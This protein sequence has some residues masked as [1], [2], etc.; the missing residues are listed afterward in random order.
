MYHTLYA[1][2]MDLQVS[3]HIT[4]GCCSSI[5][6]RSLK[7]SEVYYMRVGLM[8][9]RVSGSHLMHVPADMLHNTLIALIASRLFINQK[10]YVLSSFF[11]RRALSVTVR[12][13]RKKYKNLS[14]PALLKL[15]YLTEKKAP[16]SRFLYG[17]ILKINYTRELSDLTAL[18][19]G[20]EFECIDSLVKRGLLK[21]LPT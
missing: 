5:Q 13:V 11:L 12:S 1:E 18:I 8:V 14:D 15:L 3:D 10:R 20:N 7:T 17:G 2:N 6:S 9:V 16:S 4:M 21:N 19:I